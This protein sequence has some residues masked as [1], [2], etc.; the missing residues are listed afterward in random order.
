MIC[1]GNRKN[2]NIQTNQHGDK[3]QVSIIMSTNQ[4]QDSGGGAR[5]QSETKT[6]TWSLLSR[7]PW[8]WKEVS[9]TNT[10]QVFP[11]YL[12]IILLS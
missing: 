4:W 1:D 5:I 10:R 7:E 11:D 2:I 9:H 8:Q 6:S 3:E 12:T